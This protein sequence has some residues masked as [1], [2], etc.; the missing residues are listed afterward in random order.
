MPFSMPPRAAIRGLSLVAPG[1]GFAGVAR[2]LE[3]R[4]SCRDRRDRPRAGSARSLLL[5]GQLRVGLHMPGRAVS[6]QPFGAAYPRTR[7]EDAGARRQPRLRQ[8]HGSC[9]GAVRTRDLARLY[10]RPA[11]HGARS[12]FRGAQSG[13]DAQGDRALLYGLGGQPPARLVDALSD[14]GASSC[15]KC[16]KRPG[17]SAKRGAC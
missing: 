4:A 16:R 7:L 13:A 12:L 10:G 11:G 2:A 3:Q 15:A 8:S 17:T 9:G 6:R 5:F 14:A 1:Q